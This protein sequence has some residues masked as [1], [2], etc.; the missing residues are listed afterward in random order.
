ME[1]VFWLAARNTGLILRPQTPLSYP[2]QK[3]TM[4][5]DVTLIHSSN[6]A[7]K[8][9]TNFVLRSHYSHP[10]GNRK[11]NY[12]TDFSEHDT[13]YLRGNSTIFFGNPVSF[14]LL[15]PRIAVDYDT[16]PTWKKCHCSE[17]S[18]R[19]S[20]SKVCT[21]SSTWME[22][23]SSCS[24]ESEGQQQPHVHHKKQSLSSRSS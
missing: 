6:C 8:N 5:N 9:A 23:G 4:Q 15:P 21:Y 22:N 17:K 10:R 18:V 13:L 19:N 16:I 3:K 7:K 1:Q 24:A 14:F 12:V 2:S 20:N 11:P